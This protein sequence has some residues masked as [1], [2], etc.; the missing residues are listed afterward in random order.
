MP[1]HIV[2]EFLVIE[3][4]G[5]PPQRHREHLPRS[6]YGTKYY[7]NGSIPCP[8]ARALYFSST[9]THVGKVHGRDRDKHLGIVDVPVHQRTMSIFNGVANIPI[10]VPPIILGTSPASLAARTKA[11]V[12][13]G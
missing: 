13:G 9:S 1:A 11:T 5:S 7:P 6:P 4:S 12:S 10:N 3:N 8:F 2:G